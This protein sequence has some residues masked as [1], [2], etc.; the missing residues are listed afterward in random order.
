MHKSKFI[1]AIISE[2]NLDYSAA[3]EKYNEFEAVYGF[4]PIMYYHRGRCYYALGD[5][6]KA[7]A[8]FEHLM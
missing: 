5:S 4:T 7:N 6:V 2:L 8:D 1:Q 3:V